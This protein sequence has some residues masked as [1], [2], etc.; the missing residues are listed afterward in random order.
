MH[1]GRSAA[2]VPGGYTRGVKI[3]LA[4]INPTVGDFTGNAQLILDLSR[5]A[6]SM[7][8]DLVVFP[9]LATCGYP[10]ADLLEKPS[11]VARCGAVVEELALAT[12]ELHLAVL[13]GFVSPAPAGTGRHVQNSE[14]LLR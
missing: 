6:A 1:L 9:E 3:A 13:C 10:P 2:A 14:A 7:G 4:Q 5:R 8:A 12:A 11:F